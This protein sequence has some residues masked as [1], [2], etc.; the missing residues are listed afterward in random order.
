MAKVV[1]ACNNVYLYNRWSTE[2]PKLVTLSSFF[3]KM[4][5]TASIKALA[6]VAWKSN[7]PF[8]NKFRS[9]YSNCQCIFLKEGE[10]RKKVVYSVT[11]HAFIKQH[12]NSKG[13]WVTRTEED[14]NEELLNK[15]SFR[16]H[17]NRPKTSDQNSNLKA[18]GSLVD[19]ISTLQDFEYARA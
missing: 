11:W 9:R 3:N 13:V 7:G 10:P 18:D 5:D 2:D 4:K 16:N 14:Q 6:L 19:L 12:N 15:R 8:P 1:T 17:N